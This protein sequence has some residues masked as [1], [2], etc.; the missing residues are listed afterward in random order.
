MGK[1]ISSVYGKMGGLV[2]ISSVKGSGMWV[3]IL[4]A[5]ADYRTRGYHYLLY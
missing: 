4:K 2:K 5:G 3:G 1:I